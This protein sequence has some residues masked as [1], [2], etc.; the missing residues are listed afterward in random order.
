M[1]KL[2]QWHFIYKNWKL[3]IKDKHSSPAPSIIW[4]SKFITYCHII[5]SF[6]YQTDWIIFFKILILSWHLLNER[7][8]FRPMKTNRKITWA[9]WTKSAM[10]S[11]LKQELTT[12]DVAMS[13]WVFGQSLCAFKI[14]W[15]YMGKIGVV[16]KLVALRFFTNFFVANKI[17]SPIFPM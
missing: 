5:F 14:Y 17:R 12:L 10:N 15:I 7:I 6:N 8:C 16:R 2:T 13:K 9:L 1:R 3:A 11:M 4:L